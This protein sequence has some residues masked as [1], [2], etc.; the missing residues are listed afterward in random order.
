MMILKKIGLILA[1]IAIVGSIYIIRHEPSTNINSRE[2]G[3]GYALA[4]E[5]QD[6]QIFL[7]IALAN[8]PMRTLFGIQSA[9]STSVGTV[10]TESQTNWIRYNGIKW[11]LI[12]PTKDTPYD[13]SSLV[14]LEKRALEAATNGIQ[15]IVIIRSTPEWAQAIPGATCGPVRQDELPEFGEF[16]Y[17]LVKRYSQPPYNIKYWELWNEPDVPYTEAFKDKEFGCWGDYNDEYFGGRYYAEML[18][19]AYPQ[20]KAADPDAQVVVGGLLL[21]CDPRPPENYC[22]QWGNSD[23]PPRFFEGILLNGG[24]NYFDIVAFHGYDYFNYTAP[25]LGEFANVVWGSYWNTSGPV[26]IAKA[27]FMRDVMSQY[28]VTGKLMMNTESALV[29]RGA[30]E[31]PGGEGCEPE[32]DSPYEQTKARYITQAY[33]TAIKEDL[34]SNVWYS[35]LGWR[36]SGLVYDNLTPRPAY[37]SYSFTSTLL[38]NAKF[39]R[40]ITDNPAVRVYEF[41]HKSYTIWT[42]WALD[43]DSHAFQLPEIPDEIYD[44]MGVSEAPTITLSVDLDPL[45]IIW[46]K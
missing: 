40:E 44:Y 32:A 8:S 31:P 26:I 39:V 25:V 14:T 43:H 34:T 16:V 42:M 18:K 41:S 37:I 36:N 27:D 24:G 23:I 11:S 15:L 17:D 35:L 6:H 4:A 9:F 22:A 13:W 19:A 2:S 21:D 38:D 33:L 7:P 28:G 10:F 5:T 45:F 1:T 12:E 20:I 46:D 3:T 29:C 30:S